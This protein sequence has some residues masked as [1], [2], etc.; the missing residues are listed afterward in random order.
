[1]SCK[2]ISQNEKLLIIICLFLY[3]C[4][5]ILFIQAFCHLSQ[6]WK[7]P[8]GEKDSFEKLLFIVQLRTGYM[9]TFKISTKDCRCKWIATPSH[10]QPARSGMKMLGIII[11]QYLNQCFSILEILRQVDFTPRNLQ[12]AC[13]RKTDLN[14]QRLP[15]PEYVWHRI[16]VS[17]QTLLDF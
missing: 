6:P 10:P 9:K 1:M 16:R 17:L 7:G 5:F 2:E 11:W 12:P 8:Q 3:R 15:I 14:D 4:S 13:W